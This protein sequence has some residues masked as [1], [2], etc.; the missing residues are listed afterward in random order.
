MSIFILLSSLH[1]GNLWNHLSL[2]FFFPPDGEIIKTPLD[3]KLIIFFTSSFVIATA[4]FRYSSS[5]YSAPG[6]AIL[7]NVHHPLSC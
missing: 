7:E 1:T 5:I 6:L 2:D 4:G 3:P